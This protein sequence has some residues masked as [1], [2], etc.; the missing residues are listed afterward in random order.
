MLCAST[1]FAECRGV[2]HADHNEVICEGEAPPPKQPIKVNE[3]YEKCK[4]A[5]RS[6]L[7]SPASAQFQLS[8]PRNPITENRN[9]NK[10]M[11]VKVDA[12]NSYGGLMR[13]DMVCLLDD[14]YNVVRA[15]DQ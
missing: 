11:E 2:E 6:I 1:A 12:Q 3:I 9:G 10:Y 5:I 13:K 4:E 14:D 7:K 15:W 8:D